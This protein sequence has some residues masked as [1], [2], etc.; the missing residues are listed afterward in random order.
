MSKDVSKQ[1]REKFTEFLIGYARTGDQK[2]YL[3]DGI[4]KFAEEKGVEAGK[5]PSI[6]PVKSGKLH[7]EPVSRDDVKNLIL[8]HKKEIIEELKSLFGLTVTPPTPFRNIEDADGLY[9]LLRKKASTI[10]AGEFNSNRGAALNKIKTFSN[11]EYENNDW[12]WFL[13]KG[14]RP[15]SSEII[16]YYLDVRQ[17]YQ[18][19]ILVNILELLNTPLK[20]YMKISDHLPSTERFDEIIIYACAESRGVVENA[21]Q[22]AYKSEVIPLKGGAKIKLGDGFNKDMFYIYSTCKEIP[23]V[24]SAD[25]PVEVPGNL[26]LLWPERGAG[27]PLEIP[28]SRF[29]NDES[30][31]QHRMILILALIIRTIIKAAGSMESKLPLTEKPNFNDE[32]ST[33]NFLSKYWD[34]IFKNKLFDEE[35]EFVCKTFQVDPADFSK[36]KLGLPPKETKPKKEAESDDSIVKHIDKQIEP[37]LKDLKKNPTETLKWHDKHKAKRLE[38]IF[39]DFVKLHTLH[40]SLYNNAELQERFNK[41]TD[42]LGKTIEAWKKGKMSVYSQKTLASLMKDIMWLEETIEHL[43]KNPPKPA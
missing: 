14:G 12:D 8:N 9:Q 25:E 34:M 27:K 42:T 6:K 38:S 5:K 23:G 30:Y 26:N 29:T 10:P 39:D 36:K 16:R 32:A 2:K 3:I 11:F 7:F 31:T 20:V 21:L 17:I 37:I 40:P 1:D 33:I 18:H 4:L 43:K 35:Y 19:D 41:T 22:Q 13:N 15:T 28:L 24:Y